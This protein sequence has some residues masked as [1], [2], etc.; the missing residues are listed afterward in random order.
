MKRIFIPLALLSG[1]FAHSQVG[2]GTPEPNTSAELDITSTDKGILIPRVALKDLTDTTTITNGNVNSL[3]VFNTNETTDLQPGY[4]YWYNDRWLRMINQND[5][6]IKE[7]WKIQ[8][9]ENQAVLNTD[10][11]YQQGK[12][13]VGFTKDDEVSNKQF[14][15]KGNIKVL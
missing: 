15:V 2:I 9:T 3:I 7:P 13:A 6:S 12:V 11:I 8:N 14:E 10:D 5:S 1:A 4:Y